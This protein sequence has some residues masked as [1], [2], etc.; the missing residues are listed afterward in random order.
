MQLGAEGENG[1]R[2]PG[3]GK[4]RPTLDLLL[5]SSIGREHHERLMCAVRRMLKQVV[6]P[7]L[8]GVNFDHHYGDVDDVEDPQA[9]IIGIASD[10]PTG[11][12]ACE[13]AVAAIYFELKSAFSVRIANPGHTEEFLLIK[14]S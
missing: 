4:F 1:M 2:D 9:W 12:R 6:D 8:V 10:F 11:M 13:F 3:C 7:D 5:P 14:F